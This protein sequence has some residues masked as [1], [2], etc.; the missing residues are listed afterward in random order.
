MMVK[1]QRYQDHL[2]ALVFVFF[3]I[4]SKS[5]LFFLHLQGG[6]ENAAKTRIY[7]TGT[8]PTG[9]GGVDD[10]QN[11]EVE[12]A[13]STAAATGAAPAALAITG[14]GGV[15][16]TGDVGSS[17]ECPRMALHTML[18]QMAV[19]GPK[20]EKKGKVEESDDDGDSDK[21]ESE[22]EENGKK[23]KKTK[24]KKAKVPKEVPPEA[25]CFSLPSIP[26]T[27]DHFK[28]CFCMFL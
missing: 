7:A 22:S 5:I 17:N 3:G 15:V 1:V 10:G 18:D 6:H 9:S 11:G 25:I 24:D 4:I 20:H 13:T 14:A 21:S 19:L 12:P 27:K 2:R 23:K 28:I 8:L 26:K 16:A